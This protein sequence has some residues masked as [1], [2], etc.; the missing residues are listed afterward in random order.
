MVIQVAVVEDD[1]MMRL[2][3][4]S[5]VRLADMEVS[6]SASAA[7]EAIVLAKRLKP[8]VAILDLHLGDGPTGVDLAVALRRELPNI[9]LVFLTSFEDPRLL[10]AHL[11][12]MPAGSQYLAKSSLKGVADLV[13]AIHL[14]LEPG[15]TTDISSPTAKLT[16]NQIEL[17]RLI[18]AGLSNAEIAKRKF[19]TEKSVEVAISRIAKALG[20]GFDHTQNQRVHIARVYFRSMGIN[21]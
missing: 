13:T 20:L 19:M 7:A 14:A 1:A 2:A 8:G 10:N 9:G 15:G 18:A 3:I 5:A 11:P 16:G 17:L 12:A 6:F 21:S 4:T